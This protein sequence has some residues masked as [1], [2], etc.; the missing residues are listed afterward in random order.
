MA[1]LAKW[2]VLSMKALLLGE[3]STVVPEERLR[4]LEDEKIAKIFRKD[5]IFVEYPFFVFFGCPADLITLPGG[6]CIYRRPQH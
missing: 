4:M 5:S 2:I 6:N 3:V 1:F